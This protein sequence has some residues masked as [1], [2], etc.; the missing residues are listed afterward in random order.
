MIIVIMI[1][2]IIIILIVIVAMMMVQ[3]PAWPGL[4]NSGADNMPGS[5]SSGR[6]WI[7]AGQVGG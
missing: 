2:V 4:N 5:V 6:F 3:S 1:I 7:M